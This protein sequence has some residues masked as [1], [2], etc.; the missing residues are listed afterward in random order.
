MDSLVFSVFVAPGTSAG[1]RRAAEQSLPDQVRSA[2]TPELSQPTLSSVLSPLRQTL[3]SPRMYTSVK[4]TA[5]RHM[6]ASQCLQARMQA[7]SVRL[8]SASHPPAW[9]IVRDSLGLPG[10]RPWP[11]TIVVPHPPWPRLCGNPIGDPC[12]GWVAHW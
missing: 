3:W 12:F 8:S 4:A 2:L 10:G 11:A 9:P 1:P 6:E 5:V 7:G